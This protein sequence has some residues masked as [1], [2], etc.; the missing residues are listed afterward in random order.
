MRNKGV[1]ICKMLKGSYSV[2]NNRELWEEKGGWEKGKR[3]KEW[4]LKQKVLQRINLPR[5]SAGFP[6]V[7][8]Q[9]HG[10]RATKEA[11]KCSF[12]SRDSGT[13]L[14]I[15]NFIT[16][17]EKENGHWGTANSFCM[18]TKSWTKVRFSQPLSFQGAMN[19]WVSTTEWGPE[20]KSVARTVE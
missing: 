7:R 10:H 2:F 4:F 12:Y 15:R 14:K 9:S 8:T 18:F 13:W 5:V 19:P 6:L 20:T 1:D 17:E 16:M 11:G 3:R